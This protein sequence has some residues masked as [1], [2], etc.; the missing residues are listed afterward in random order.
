VTLVGGG[1]VG[2]HQLGDGG[3]GFMHIGE[4]GVIAGLLTAENGFTLSVRLLSMVSG[5]SS[6]SSSASEATEKTSSGWSF[7]RRAGSARGL[8]NSRYSVPRLAGS[9]VTARPT[10]IAFAAVGKVRADFH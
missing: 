9:S 5:T 2:L 4:T 3:H 6:N 1:E 7:Y 10:R 8:Q